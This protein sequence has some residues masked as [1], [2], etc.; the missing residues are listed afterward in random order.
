MGRH[1]PA[2]LAEPFEQRLHPATSAELPP[3]CPSPDRTIYSPKQIPLV[4]IVEQLEALLVDHVGAYLV[5]T[6]LY[7]PTIFGHS[8]TLLLLEKL[9]Q[10]FFMYGEDIDL[11]YRIL[12]G[13]YQNY[14][15]PQ[16]FAHLLPQQLV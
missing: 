9:E 8:Q 12:K 3:P 4:I 10:D 2:N 6:V 14:Y 11:S 15:L 1:V 13:G 7:H 16:G 5:L